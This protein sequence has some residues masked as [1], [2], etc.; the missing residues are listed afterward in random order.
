MSEA[1]RKRRQDYKKNRAKWI[2]IQSIAIALVA[3]I[4][5][6][7]F[8]TYSRMNRTY[9]IEYV[10]HGDISY[11]V[12]YTENNFFDE[13]WIGQ[14]QAYVVSLIDDLLADFKYDLAVDADKVGFDYQY[15]ITAQVLVFDKTSG[16]PLYSPTFELL[17]EK[18]E[19]VNGNS[20]RIREQLHVDYP[21]YNRLANTFVNTY[22]IV[23]STA[24]LSVTLN[25]NVLGNCDAFEDDSQNAYFVSLNVPLNVDTADASVTSSVTDGESKI[26]ACSGAANQNVFLILGIVCASLALILVTV[27]VAFTYLT[28]NE[29]INYTIRV[30]KLVSSYRSF[31]QAMDGEFDTEGYQSVRIKSFVELLGIRDTIQSPI[32]MSENADQTCTSFLIPTNTKLLYVY[33]VKVDNYDEIYGIPAEEPDTAEEPIILDD[34]VDMESVAEAI[35]EPD[36]DLSEIEYVP[37]DDDDFAVEEDE[38][39]VEVVGVVWPERA[40]KNKVY[41]YDPNGERLYEGDVVLVPTRDVERERE[42]I[43]KAAV[44]HENHRVEPEHIKHPLK[45]I[46]GIVKRKVEEALVPVE[47]S[48]HDHTEES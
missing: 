9:Y 3:L 16:D 5:L 41:R 48:S 27:L 11:R 10:E 22:G 17:P 37:D 2:L 38:P 29:D 44:A 43:R 26:L 12:H 39:G 32:L 33:E 45:K 24:T 1:E 7:S 20:V 23:G 47:T 14:D 25:V 46:I 31:I 28:R 35:A 18:T 8:F 15:S 6:V 36:V 4:A 42:V 34:T 13:E 30:K 21:T 19:T 40:H